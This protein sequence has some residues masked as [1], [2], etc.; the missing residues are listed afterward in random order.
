MFRNI[1]RDPM[2]TKDLA[3]GESIAWGT[4]QEL[5]ATQMPG[6]D[7]EGVDNPGDTHDSDEELSCFTYGS[8]KEGEET[9]GV[10][11][12]LRQADGRTKLLGLKG[13]T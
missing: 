2:E 10:G 3:I 7:A 11:W 4:A 8:W 12:V 1:D 6:I 5:R 13:N 9:I